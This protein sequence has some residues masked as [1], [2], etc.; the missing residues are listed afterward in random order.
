MLSTIA[1]RDTIRRHQEAIQRALQRRATA[2]PVDCKI[3]YRP[4]T[5][6]VRVYWLPK[7]WIWCYT[8]PLNNRYWNAFGV[9]E[10]SPGARLRIAVEINIPF[11][12][13]HHNIGGVLVAAP[14]GQVFLGHRGRFGGGSR[15]IN[16]A[17]FLDWFREQLDETVDHAVASPITVIG[18]VGDP[19]LPEQL[20]TFIHQ[21]AA[22]KAR[23]R[24]AS[25]S[26][27][28]PQSWLPRFHPEF[29]GTR[30]YALR[31]PV[32]AK[33]HH[34]LIV[35]TLA[36]NLTTLGT[37]VHN[38]RHQDLLAAEGR[39]AHRTTLF[40]VKTDATLGSVY[41]AIGQL[42]YHAGA[43]SAGWRLVA[44]LPSGYPST[45]AA[46]LRALDIAVL[47]FRLT[48]SGVQFPSLRRYV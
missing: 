36:R 39:G 41:T 21:C 3:I 43:R 45:I 15:G 1:D 25:A 33:C 48:R 38:T 14:N 42:L 4:Y 30:E 29:T 18:E 26:E 16:K 40:E 7:L 23:R 2:P 11:F 27:K 37:A 5:E 22:L 46:R 32:A 10:P 31:G 28:D 20:A 34:G 35:N 44:V 17:V 6:Q 47:P 12:G 9:T 24:P 19:H 13:S 8:K